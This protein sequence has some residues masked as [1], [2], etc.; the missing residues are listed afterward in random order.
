MGY[1]LTQ[2]NAFIDRIAPIIQTEAKK[3]GY[4]VCSTVI[5]QAIIEGAAGTS[6][7]AKKYYNHFGLKCGKAW[8]NAGKPSVSLKTKEEYKVGTLTTINDYFRV[9]SGDIEGVAGY[10]DFISTNRYANLKTAKTYTQYAE[11]LK[12]DGYATSSTYVNTL[13]KTVEK[14]GLQKFDGSGQTTSGLKSIDEIANEVIANLWG[15]G[16][17]RKQRLTAS[18]YDY[19]TVQK[20]V[21]EILKGK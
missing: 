16:E 8:L 20:R 6:T 5:A 1:T 9:Y 10:Y 12:S 17:T 14:Y 13:C 18:G 4:L 2:A 11:R 19:A 7:L 3:R 21:N 15:N